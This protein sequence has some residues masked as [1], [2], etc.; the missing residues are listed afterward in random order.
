MKNIFKMD[1][2][3][4]GGKLEVLGI[5]IGGSGIKGALVDTLSGNLLTD[6]NRIPTPE[7]AD[8]KDVVKAL[9]QLVKFFGYH[10][11]VGC[12]FPAVIQHGVARTAA[13]ISDKWIGINVDKLFSDALCQP[14]FT[15]NDA[16]AAGWAEMRFG[17]GQEYR[18]GVV[19][20]LT[21]GT[22]IGSAIFS[23]GVLVPNTEFGHLKI[24][25]MEAEHRASD[26]VRQSKELSW[27]KW[28]HELND[29][30]LVME[31]LFSPDVFIVGGGVSKKWEKIAPYL[32]TR[33]KIMPAQLLNQAGIIGGAIY[34]ENCLNTSGQNPA[35][36]ELP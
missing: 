4:F 2:N 6:R 21:I 20:L 14:V 16:D 17:V 32:T 34:A 11:P 3:N 12:G 31:G 19:I 30:L 25:G 10:G 29:F 13:N 1:V 18:N 15:L 9:E 28:A 33:G 7:G 36:G 27:R 24:K 35:L 23:D 22:G 8:P 5:D 26:A